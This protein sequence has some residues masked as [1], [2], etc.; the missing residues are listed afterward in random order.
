MERITE[1][2]CIHVL[3]KAPCTHSELTDTIM[4][5]HDNAD[6]LDGILNDIADFQE[7]DAYTY[8]NFLSLLLLHNI[9]EIDFLDA[10]CF[11]H[12]L[13]DINNAGL[14]QKPCNVFLF[15]MYI[16]K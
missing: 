16:T 10:T 9:L 3:A 12:I 2:H 5:S 11:C 13:L 8:I 15:I 14:F 1:Y 4:K 7:P 6:F